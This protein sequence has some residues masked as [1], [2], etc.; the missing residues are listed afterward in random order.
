M[1][2]AALLSGCVTKS[3][4][5]YCDIAQPIRPSVHDVLTDETKIQV[6]IENEKYAALC[7]G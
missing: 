1:W 6:V 2:I 3:S 7:K 4:G 5:Q